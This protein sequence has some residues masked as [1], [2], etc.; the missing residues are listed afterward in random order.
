MWSQRG[1][2]EPPRLVNCEDEADQA[3]YL[4]RQILTHRE[5]GVDLRR[6]AVLFRA[7]HHSILLEAELVRRDIPFQ[8]FGGLK[9]METAHVKDLLAFLRLAENPRD[10]VAGGRVLPLMPGIGPGKARQLMAML[11]ASGGNFQVW[12]DWKPPAAAAEIWPRMVTSG[13]KPG[14]TERKSARPNRPGP[15]ILCAASGNA[16]RQRPAPPSRLG[17]IGTDRLALQKPAADAVGTDARSAV[18]DPGPGRPAHIGRR[19]SGPKH[20]P[21]GQGPGMGRGLRDPCRRRL[22]PLGHGHQRSRRRSK[23]SGACFTWPL[24]GRKTGSTFAIRCVFTTVFTRATS[25]VMPSGPDSCPNRFYP[26]SNNA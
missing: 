4:I 7:S 20:D 19:L 18:I 13:A 3:E 9:F 24:P 15:R 12:A 14:E 16:L 6:Q 21:L 1:A 11:L 5:S 23:K 10:V 8:K 25:T 22:H 26:H 2:G 17:T